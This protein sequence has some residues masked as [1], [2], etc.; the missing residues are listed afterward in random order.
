MKDKKINDVDV[1]E[2]NSIKNEELF[3]GKD[4]DIVLNCEGNPCNFVLKNLI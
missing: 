1:N 3:V 2:K 4:D